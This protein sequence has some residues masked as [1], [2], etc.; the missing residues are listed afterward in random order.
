MLD[1]VGG[2]KEAVKARENGTNNSHDITNSIFLSTLLSRCL[3][4]RQLVGLWHRSR[5]GL[6]VLIDANKHP[7]LKNGLNGRRMTNAPKG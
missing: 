2:Q 1:C 4:D 6:S 5:S 7:V 3:N